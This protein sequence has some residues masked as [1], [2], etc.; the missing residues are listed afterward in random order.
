VRGI[1]RKQKAIISGRCFVVKEMLA[2]IPSARFAVH[3]M[4][5]HSIIV[6]CAIPS[7]EAIEGVVEQ[8][9]EKW[10]DV[11]AVTYRYEGASPYLH[12]VFDCSH[13]GHG[14]SSGVEG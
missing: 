10:D 6:N 4:T 11:V 1:G 9:W 12:V 2:K 5:E 7:P 13:Q 3:G 14:A 8:I